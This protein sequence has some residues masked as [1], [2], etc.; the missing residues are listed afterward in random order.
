VDARL[1]FVAPPVRCEYLPQEVAR[2]EYLQVDRMTAVEYRD[3]L[4]RGW[5]RFGHLL[6]RPACPSCRACWSL[7]VPVA[8]FEPHRTQR[9]IW[10]ANSGSVTLAI[11]EPS[12][13]PMTRAL[14]EKFHRHQQAAKGWPATDP[15]GADGFAE[16]PFPTEEWRYAVE[17]RPV[18]VGYVDV[19]PESLSAI[20]FFYDPDERR[21][22]LGTFN[23]L[24]IIDEARRRGLPWVYLGYYV[25]GCRSLEYKGRFAP[26]EVLA[27]DGAWMPFIRS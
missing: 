25:E 1:R 22:S 21:R 24:S 5:R 19:L 14:Y 9:R 23:V 4:R 12:P 3:W 13:S 2:L 16:N 20:Y 6:F 10:K 8:S 17:G 7:R 18:A 11:G 27:P 26:N 15:G